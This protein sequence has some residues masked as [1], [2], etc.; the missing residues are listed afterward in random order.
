MFYDAP[1]FNLMNEIQHPLSE[2]IAGGVDR[3]N[4]RDDQDQGAKSINQ[5][6]EHESFL[7]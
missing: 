1:R 4:G 3:D 6:F 7:D 5:K 2:K